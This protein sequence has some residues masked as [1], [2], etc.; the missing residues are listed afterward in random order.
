MSKDKNE[1][2]QKS[3]QSGVRN[4]ANVCKLQNLSIFWKI[5]SEFGRIIHNTS[6]LTKNGLLDSTFAQKST[7]YESTFCILCHLW[8]LLLSRIKNLLLKSLSNKIIGTRCHFLCE[9]L[10]ICGDLMI[11]FLGNDVQNLCTLYILIFKETTFF[12]T[13]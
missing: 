1:R 11:I 2:I 6:N 3:G 12:C 9:I 8:S 10:Q 5:L 4:G 13:F 7:R